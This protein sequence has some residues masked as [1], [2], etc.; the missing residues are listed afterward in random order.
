MSYTYNSSLVYP[1]RMLARGKCKFEGEKTSTWIFYLDVPLE[2]SKCLVNGL[3]TG[4][5]MEV[6]N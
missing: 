3:C 5:S 4:V 1:F 2:V 6:S